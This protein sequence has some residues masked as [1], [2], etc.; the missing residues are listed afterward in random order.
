MILIVP[1][2]FLIGNGIAFALRRRVSLIGSHING[3]GFGIRLIFRGFFNCSGF[4]SSLGE[5][6][7]LA[8]FVGGLF[9]TFFNGSLFLAAFS[10]FFFARFG[11]AFLSGA[12]LER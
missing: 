1:R 6:G 11:R 5:L 3:F 10:G 8:L 12:I 4:L 7:F 9:G 2:A